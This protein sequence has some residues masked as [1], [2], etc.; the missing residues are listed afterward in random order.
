METIPVD[1]VQRGLFLAPFPFSELSFEKVRPVLVMTNNQYN[2]TSSDVLVCPLTTKL[3]KEFSIEIN[4]KHLEQ[5]NLFSSSAIRYD[6]CFSI[7]ALLL[8]KQIGVLDQKTFEEIKEKI[9][10]LLK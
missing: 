6:S 10:K 2:K 5:G 4:S 9:C 7:D 8:I 1:I 3:G